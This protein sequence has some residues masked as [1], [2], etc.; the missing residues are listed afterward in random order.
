MGDRSGA[1]GYLL[2]EPVV[3]TEGLMMDAPYLELIRKQLPL[4]EVLKRYNVRYYVGSAKK[5]FTG[6]FNAKEPAQA[7]P[8]SSHLEADFCEAPV[9]RWSFAG[10]QTMIFDL[11]PQHP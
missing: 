9:A 5:P 4:R 3:Q 11:H 6:C 7:G 1:V 10:V 8:H 2:D